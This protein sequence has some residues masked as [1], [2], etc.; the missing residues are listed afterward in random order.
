MCISTPPRFGTKKSE[1]IAMRSFY[2]GSFNASV[3]AEKFPKWLFVT[4]L[5]FGGN[6]K[7]ISSGI[8]FK[9]DLER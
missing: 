3:A 6:S 8:M 4:N 7:L 9:V 2:R 5:S 1:M